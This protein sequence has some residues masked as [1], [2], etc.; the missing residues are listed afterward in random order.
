MKKNS[1]HLGISDGVFLEGIQWAQ[2]KTP[3][4]Q[5]FADRYLKYGSYHFTLQSEI[6]LKKWQFLGKGGHWLNSH[7]NLLVLASYIRFVPIPW[8]YLPRG[9]KHSTGQIGMN[10]R[11]WALGTRGWA[12]GGYVMYLPTHAPVPFESHT[13][14]QRPS[15]EK[16]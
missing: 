12:W 5:P 11:A 7:T 9:K 6:S 15:M 16:K 10:W 1:S 3:K 14:K 13:P 4:I 8:A 2:R